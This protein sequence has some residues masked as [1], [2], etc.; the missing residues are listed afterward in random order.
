MI[1]TIRHRTAYRYAELV[2][3]G[4]HRLMIR[5]RDSFDMQLRR[6]ELVS[7]PP[8][9]LR[10]MHDPLGN[11]I[12]IATFG[13]PTN[14]L[15][16]TSTLEIERFDST[17]PAFAPPAATAFPIVYG[18]AE[19]PELTPFV[20]PAT[21]DPSLVLKAFMQ[22]PMAAAGQSG[23]DFLAGLNEKVHGHVSYARRDEEGTQAPVD[24][25]ERG[26]GS[27][28][29]MAWLFVECARRAGFAA[30]FVSGYLYDQATDAALGGLVGGGATHAWA[31][32]YVPETGWVEYDPTNLLVAGHALLRVAVART[33]EL[34]SPISGTFTGSTGAFL[35]IE[36]SV[37]ISSR[38]AEA[39]EAEAVAA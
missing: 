1:F 39:R 19:V 4:P 3:L 37:E 36:V 32:I 31:E 9:S 33:P 6:A 29:D 25:V 22:E 35:G 17:Q 8:A 14:L 21:D 34:A 10:W 20:T 38:E 28:R 24:T 23:L 11:A 26:T 5:P 15:E 18:A 16:I 7:T 2:T 27:C 12:A 30:R 13:A